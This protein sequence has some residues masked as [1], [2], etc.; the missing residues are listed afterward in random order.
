MQPYKT[1]PQS[2]QNY[3]WMEF[4]TQ[5]FTVKEK[6]T[7]KSTFLS[8]QHFKRFRYPYADLDAFFVSLKMEKCFLIGLWTKDPEVGGTGGQEGTDIIIH[9]VYVTIEAL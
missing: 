5:T 3:Y 9:V 8:K 2:F 4:A 7:V 1:A 6:P